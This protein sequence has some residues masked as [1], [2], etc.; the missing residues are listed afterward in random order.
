MIN[1]NEAI[2]RIKQVG[3]ANVRIVPM[4]GQ[5]ALNGMH[6]IEIRNGDA[7][8]VIVENI[9]LRAAEA[10]VIQATNRVILG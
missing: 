4:D 1:L 7:W 3:A 9:P 5:P 10:V 8:Q 2:T 6:R